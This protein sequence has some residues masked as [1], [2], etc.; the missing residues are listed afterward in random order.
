MTSTALNPAQLASAVSGITNHTNFILLGYPRCGSNLLLSALGNHPQIRMIGEVLSA[1]ETVRSE[2]WVRVNPTAW[3]PPRGEGYR[4]GQ[5]AAEFLQKNIFSDRPL[6]NLCAF[7]FK[8]FYDHARFDQASSTAWDYLLTQDIKVIH[9]IRR[10]LLYSLISQEVAERTNLWY[11]TADDPTAP[12]PPLAPFDL[13]PA[14][15]RTYFDYVS[16]R[17]AWAEEAFARHSMLT[18]EYE[19]YL[20]ANFKDTNFRVHQFLGALP[21][22]LRPNMAKQQALTARQQISNFETLNNYFA[23]SAYANFFLD[24]DSP[25]AVSPARI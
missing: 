11:R 19:K 20:C 15:C 13:D 16:E 9:L 23:G 2:A 17:R 12:P 4:A 5:N 22:H 10:N 25:E 8:I 24:A 21:W 1:D 6:E 3:P 18:I 14:A 7:G